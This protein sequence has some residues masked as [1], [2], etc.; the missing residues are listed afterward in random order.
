M[1]KKK[2]SK[3]MKVKLETASKLAKPIEHNGSTV[4][5]SKRKQPK[6]ASDSADP[7][8]GRMFADP[9]PSPDDLSFDASADSGIKTD[10]KQAEPFPTT[11]LASAVITLEEVIGTAAVSAIQ[12]AGQIV[13]HC[14]GDTGGVKSPAHQF[15]VADKMELDYSAPNS[16]DQPS[17]FYHLGDVVYYFGQRQFYSDQFYDP[18]RHYPGPIFAIPGNHDGDVFPGE[19][20]ASLAAF[21]EN[22]CTPTPIHSPDAADYI[23]TTMTQPGVYFTLSAPFVKIIGLYSNALESPGVISSESGKYPISDDQLDF[24]VAQLQEAKQA[25]D[26]GDSSAVLVA[27]HHPPYSGDAEHGGSPNMLADLDAAVKKAG[28]IPDAYFS[29][30][31]HI[32]ERFTRH[33]QRQANPVCRLRDRRLSEPGVNETPAQRQGAFSRQCAAALPLARRPTTSSRRLSS[34][35]GDTC[36]S[37]LRTAS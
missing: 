10:T 34:T 8:S 37:S 14:V 29:G 11:P 4:K 9:R 24:L 17:F 32:Y 31:A 27:V 5:G 23:R 6:P 36:D 1:S 19:N 20:T 22:F 12:K 7:S 30:H 2:K 25:R 13:F 28:F 15:L 35:A 18:Y 3:K 16:A 33:R 26:G 21:I